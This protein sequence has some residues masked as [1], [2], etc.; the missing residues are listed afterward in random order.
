MQRL[1]RSR[2][3]HDRWCRV[4]Q[5]L[6]FVFDE[7]LHVFVMPGHH[8]RQL[9][10]S[11]W[12]TTA[13]PFHEFMTETE[14]KSGFS[15]KLHEMITDG[16]L[17]H[18]YWQQT[19][20]TTDPSPDYH[21]SFVASLVLCAHAVSYVQEDSVIGFWCEYL[22]TSTRTLSVVV[23]NRSAVQVRLQGMQQPADCAHVLTLVLFRSRTRRV[24]KTTARRR[25]VALIRR[26]SCR[27]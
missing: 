5:T 24:A 21:L 17:P 22:V 16:S 25:R 26:L 2:R 12:S 9:S 27:A 13:L 7:F 1:G 23:R 6:D 10:R 3:R 20:V 8:K 19:F 11:M 15:T 18:A 14:V 4:R